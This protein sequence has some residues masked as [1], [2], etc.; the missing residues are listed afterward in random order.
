MAIRYSLAEKKSNFSKESQKGK[1]YAVAQHNGVLSEAEFAK[2][3]SQMCHTLDPATVRSV[4]AVVAECLRLQLL[5]GLLVR[6]GALGDFYTVIK[7]TG[8]TNT[9]N[10]ARSNIKDVQVNWRPGKPLRN[11]M[12]KAKFHLAD[13][14]RVQ[15]E[16]KR[17]NKHRVQEELDESNAM[18]EERLKDNIIEEWSTARDS[19]V[20]ARV[21]SVIRENP[22]ITVLAMG[23]LCGFTLYEAKVTINKM[24]EAGLVRRVG[25]KKGGHWE[26]ITA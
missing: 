25:P 19:E 5:E 26:I 16:A 6:T 11:L 22:R 9:A 21:L 12:G 10:F 4:L 23:E 20:Y 15:A 13:P 17:L 1:F 14:R 7:G 18:R 24:R 2:R 8:S 3:V